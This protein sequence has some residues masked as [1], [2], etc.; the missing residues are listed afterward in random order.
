[1]IAA[2]AATVGACGSNPQTGVVTDDRDRTADD[3]A[4][5]V[6]VLREVVDLPEMETAPPRPRVFVEPLD[7]SVRLPLD[8]QAAV[9]TA[10]AEVA[11]LRFIDK[12]EEATDGKDPEAPIRD[13]GTIVALGPLVHVGDDA[14]SLTLRRA[15]SQDDEELLVASIARTGGGWRVVTIGPV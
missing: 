9:V 5:Y 3:A 12:R 1:M 8:V 2:L 10:L 7:E 4:V 13:G 6:A 15:T 14:R 11:D